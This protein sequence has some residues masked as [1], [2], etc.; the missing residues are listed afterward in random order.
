MEFYLI[1][2]LHGSLCAASLALVVATIKKRG[3]TTLSLGAASFF[4][5]S[6]LGLIFSHYVNYGAA[7]SFGDDSGMIVYRKLTDVYIRQAISH[8]ILMGVFCFA[9]LLPKNI[10]LI[11]VGKF[12][13]FRPPMWRG[14]LILLAILG[15]TRYFIFGPGLGTLLETNLIYFSAED[16]VAARSSANAN[17][18]GQGAYMAA[19]VAYIILPVLFASRVLIGQ[20]REKIQRPAGYFFEISCFFLLSFIYAFQTRQKA[21]IISTVLIY[22]LLHI[23]RSSRASQEKFGREARGKYVQKALMFGGGI[24]S[25]AIALYV[26]V[27]GM[28]VLDSIF[29]TITRVLF[30]PT[31][32]E[33]NYFYAFPDILSFRGLIDSYIIRVFN[34]PGVSGVSIYD[35]AIA[36]TGNEFSANASFLAVGWSGFGYLGV[37]LVSISLCFGLLVLLSLIHI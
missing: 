35:V 31:A 30:V 6:S 21:P 37:L 22:L 24:F 18:Y 16:A 23:C 14:I 15:Y 28:S 13:L 25:L 34:P 9:L 17:F 19:V 3:L 27:F 1:S 4:A 5:I 8:W 33:A 11:N 26:L 7:L 2:V 10:F 32:T 20:K 12:A 36:A 29:A